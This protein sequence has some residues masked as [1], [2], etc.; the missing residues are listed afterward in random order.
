MARLVTILPQRP[1]WPG[2]EVSFFALTWEEL[3]VCAK[4]MRNLAGVQCPHIV[5]PTHFFV[6]APQ[7]PSG[8]KRKLRFLP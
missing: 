2:N 4:D 5:T 6:P 3:F 8:H 7:L 1:L